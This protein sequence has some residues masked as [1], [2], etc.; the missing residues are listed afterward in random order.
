MS[1]C[2]KGLP[3]VERLLDC[4]TPQWEALTQP[5]HEV[6]SA[7]W[8]DQPAW[9]SPLVVEVVTLFDVR[10]QSG[11]LWP[12]SE[13]LLCQ[14]ARRRVVGRHEGGKKA[15][16]GAGVLGGD[17]DDRQVQVAADDLSDGLEWHTFF[18]GYV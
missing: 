10:D 5:R 1:V 4:S 3:A 14:F 7:Y 15:E 13:A 18:G 6:V 11:P 17:A 2:Q 16:V 12:P 8:F 9:T